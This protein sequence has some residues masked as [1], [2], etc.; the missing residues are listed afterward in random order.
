MQYQV[1]ACARSLACP[2]PPPSPPPPQVL[3]IN[4]PAQWGGLSNRTHSVLAPPGTQ[5]DEAFVQQVYD[6]S[7][8]RTA[9]CC[10]RSRCFV[11]AWRGVAAAASAAAAAAA[12]APHRTSPASLAPHGSPARMQNYQAFKRRVHSGPANVSMRVRHAEEVLGEFA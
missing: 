3:S 11:S 6:V 4:F 10:P 5:P 2:L 9:G 7:A 1:A 12:V 8:F